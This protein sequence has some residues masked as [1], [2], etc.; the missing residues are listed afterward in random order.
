[1]KLKHCCLTE[2]QQDRLLDAQVLFWLYRSIPR[3]IFALPDKAKTTS[4]H[5]AGDPAVFPLRKNALAS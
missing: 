2:N 4:G 3:L 5:Q 1:M